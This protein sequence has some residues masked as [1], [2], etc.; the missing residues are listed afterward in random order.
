MSLCS[1]FHIPWP[2]VRQP[3]VSA[4][5]FRVLYFRI[6]AEFRN[7]ANLE[8]HGAEVGYDVILRSVVGCRYTYRIPDVA[9]A[10]PAEKMSSG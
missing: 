3:N 8:L 5:C 4:T 1:V 10:Q 7:M 9:I 2:H 6:D